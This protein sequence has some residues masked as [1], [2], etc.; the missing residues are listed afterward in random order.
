[1]SLQLTSSSSSKSQSEPSFCTPAKPKRSPNRAASLRLCNAKTIDVPIPPSLLQ[2]PYLNSPM[3]PFQK[4]SSAPCTPSREDEQW[5]RD[6]I[7]LSNHSAPL[8]RSASTKENVQRR[9]CSSPKCSDIDTTERGEVMDKTARNRIGPYSPPLVRLGT[10]QPGQDKVQTPSLH[11]PRAG[12]QEYF[13]LS[14]A[15]R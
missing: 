5:L 12:D 13:L 8:G 15:G 7:P 11:L 10:R 4:A 1:M 9:T 14:H 3:S 6:T 2:S